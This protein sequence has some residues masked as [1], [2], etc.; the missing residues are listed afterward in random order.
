MDPVV[1]DGKSET[2]LQPEVVV[3]ALKHYKQP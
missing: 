2:E 1:E 3:Y